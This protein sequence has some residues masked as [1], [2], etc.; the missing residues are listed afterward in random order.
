MSTLELEIRKSELARKILNES[1]EDVVNMLMVFFREI[2]THTAKL[3]CQF[4]VEQLKSEIAEAMDDVRN[5]RMTTHE[6]L[7]KEMLLW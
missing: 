5:G 6:E 4:T 1:N 7:G 3:P 2:E